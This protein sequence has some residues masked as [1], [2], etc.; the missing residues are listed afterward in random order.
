VVEDVDIDVKA[1]PNIFYVNIQNILNEYSDENVNLITHSF[2][3]QQ[4]RE[5]RR[6][7]DLGRER[8]LEATHIIHNQEEKI[9]LL[10]INNQKLKEEKSIV[11]SNVAKRNKII[12]ILVLSFLLISI[13]MVVY[14]FI[15]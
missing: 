8:E 3:E 14:H 1:I 7:Y 12:T 6:E 11:E 13:C 15:R 2:V 5:A 10:E 4:M 9:N